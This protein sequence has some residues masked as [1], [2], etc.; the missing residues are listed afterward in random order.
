M[1]VQDGWTELLDQPVQTPACVHVAFVRT[2]G[3]NI[4]L[5]QVFL[6]LFRLVSPA[7]LECCAVD[8]HE[9]EQQQRRV[10]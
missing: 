6:S 4:K 3:H 8:A 2:R 10:A 7:W 1:L 9:M 5:R